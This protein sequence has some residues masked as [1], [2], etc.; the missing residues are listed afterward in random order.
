VPDPVCEPAQPKK[1]RQSRLAVGSWWQ[2]VPC[3]KCGALRGQSCEAKNLRSTAPHAARRKAT[4]E[5]L[6]QGFGHRAAEVPNAD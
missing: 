5:W 4:V 6:S 3:P 1:Q 2:H